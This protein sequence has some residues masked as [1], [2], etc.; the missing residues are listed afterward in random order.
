MPATIAPTKPIPLIIPAPS[1]TSPGP[2]QMPA[3]PQPMP[4]RIAPPIKRLSIC[5]LVGRFIAPPHTEWVR[6]F[7]DRK[8]KKPTLMAPPITK[9]REGSQMR[10]ISR[11]PITFAG[12]AMPLS[13]NPTPNIAPANRE[14]NRFI[15]V[16]LSDLLCEQA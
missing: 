2:G 16:P 3:S 1:N 8:A 13:I 10:V 15:Y 9:A 11:K 5:L 4:N 12:F 14:K 6:R 7:T